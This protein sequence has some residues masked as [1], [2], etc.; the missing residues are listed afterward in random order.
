[1]IVTIVAKMVEDSQQKVNKSD[2]AEEEGN[3]KRKVAQF[4]QGLCQ[5]TEK[6]PRLVEE[7]LVAKQE[8]G[9]T[10]NAMMDRDSLM[11]HFDN[12]RRGRER[13]E[14]F[15]GF[16]QQNMETGLISLVGGNSGPACACVVEMEDADDDLPELEVMCCPSWM[17]ECDKCKD[18]PLVD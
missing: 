8:T 4:E 13:S 10:C 12:V 16:Y 3:N 7:K 5:E 17:H 2:G 15:E 11:R 1:M 6:K 18:I 9:R 14:S